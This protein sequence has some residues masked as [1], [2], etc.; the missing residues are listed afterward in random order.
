MFTTRAIKAKQWKVAKLVFLICSWM[1]LKAV[2]GVLAGYAL[3]RRAT[4]ALNFR[5]AQRQPAPLRSTTTLK[6]RR[7]YVLIYQLALCILM[8]CFGKYCSLH[9]KI[10]RAQVQFNGGQSGILVCRVWRRVCS[11]VEAA[12]AAAEGTTMVLRSI[13]VQQSILVHDGALV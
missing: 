1:T 9:R 12:P 3:A 7:H 10:Y 6:K 4:R 8:Q 5:R 13:L 2:L 11:R